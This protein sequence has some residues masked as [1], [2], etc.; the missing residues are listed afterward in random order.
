MQ[1]VRIERE[2]ELL[3]GL[4]DANARILC[5]GTDLLIKIRSGMTSPSR[6]LDISDVATMRGVMSEADAVTI[7]HRFPLTDR[8]RGLQLFPKP[9]VG[10]L[11]CLHQHRIHHHWHIETAALETSGIGTPHLQQVGKHAAGFF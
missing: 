9:G 4:G 6:L 1:V 3:R 10:K 11:Q 2:E 7:Q 8:I 5:G